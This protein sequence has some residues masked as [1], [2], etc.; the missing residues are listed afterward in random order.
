VIQVERTGRD[1]RKSGFVHSEQVREY[2]LAHGEIEP[3]HVVVKSSQ[4]DELQ[5]R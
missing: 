2:L 5:R 3:E 4:K 1:Q